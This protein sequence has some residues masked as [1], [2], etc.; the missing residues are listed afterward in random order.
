MSNSGGRPNWLKPAYDFVR[1]P[2]Y[3][4]LDMTNTSKSVMAFNLS[5]L[6]ER[7][8]FVEL[9]FGDIGRWLRNGDLKPPPVTTYALSDVAQAHKGIESGTTVGKLVLIP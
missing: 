2:R 9:A 3:G 7:A 1:R 4:P 6:F 8:D 5:Y